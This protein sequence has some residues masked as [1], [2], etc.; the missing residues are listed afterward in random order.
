M[1]FSLKKI[2]KGI[3]LREEGTQTPKEMEII[4][5]GSA[6]T[7]TTVTS[8]QTAAR[9][10]TLPDATDTLVGKATTDILT[11]KSIDSNT[12]T[13]TNIKNAD[14]K[15]AA[16]I[17]AAKIADGSVS[18]SAYQQVTGLTSP[19]VGTTQTQTLTNKTISG[20][21]NTITNVSLTSAVSGVLPI[22]NGGSGQSTQ[23]TA[24]N[25]LSPLTTKGDIIVHNGS[26]N[27]R[28]AI[29][30]DAQGLIADS[31]QASGVK[32]G[33]LTP[34]NSA[35]V[36]TFAGTGVQTVFTLTSSPGSLNATQVFIDGVAQPKS[37][38]SVSST[39]LTFTEAPPINTI[40]EV[41]YGTVLAIAVPA[42]L[43]VT[44][45]KLVDGS[46]TPV[47]KS[48]L[49][50]QLSSSS[51][52]FTTTSASF[53]DVTNLSVTITCTGRP[54]FVGIIFDGNQS[55]NPSILTCT[56]A[57]SAGLTLQILRDNTTTVCSMQVSS[58]ISLFP[59]NPF[60][61][62]VD[63]VSAGTYAYKVQ[64]ARIGTNATLSN[65]KLIAYEL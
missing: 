52:S 11:N 42:D 41:N 10:I 16:A 48:A 39:T 6:S 24:F 34:A 49:G 27:I 55:L 38:Y 63:I 15:S 59:T 13:I 9:T 2:I 14:I 25:A 46:V 57:G 18:N 30:A 53:V 32:W 50:Q 65:V 1:A 64:L 58:N 62:T 47:K 7:K 60:L 8:S 22:S 21:S 33:N 54:V 40:I 37:T 3:L 12:N 31:T 4:P 61:N 43:S 35:N 44:T 29:G 56:S 51:G 17:D 5:G 36:D 23:T 45:A 28:L 19:A 26:N 20:A